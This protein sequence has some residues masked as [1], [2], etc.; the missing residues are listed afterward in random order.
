M[1]SIIKSHF[2]KG[3][4]GFLITGIF[5]IL[6]V[7]MMTIGLSI[8]FGM[9]KLYFNARN[10][11]N[12]ADC[13]ISVFE[14][15]GGETQKLLEDIL[16]KREDVESY[17]VRTIYYMEKRAVE[18]V[19]NR[20][21]IFNDKGQTSGFNSWVALNID[22]DSDK[23]KPHLRDTVEKDGYKFYITGNY[24][25]TMFCSIGDRVEFENGGNTYVGYVAGIY[26]DMA[27]IY[28]H[29]NIF[30]SGDLF[31]EIARISQTDDSVTEEYEINVRLDYVDEKK[32]E[33]AQY[34]VCEALT[35]ALGEYN[36]RNLMQDPTFSVVYCNDYMRETFKSGTKAF[37]LLLG[38]A[39]IAFSV[40]VAVIVAIV[41]AFLTRSNILDE[42]R[43]LGVWKA[44][45]YTTKQLRLSYL[46]IYGV[47]GLICLTIGAILGV[48][49]M[50]TFVGIITNMARLDL[51]KAIGT[52]I[53]GV[54]IAIVFIVAVLSAVVYLSTSKVKKITPLS[55]MRNNIQTHSFK[56]NKAPLNKSKISLDA[57]LGVKSVVGESRRS[58]MVVAIVLI[59][60]ILCSFVSVVYYN[61]K[62]DQTAIINMSGV[63]NADFYISFY[64]EDP[65]P[66]YDAIREMEG[67]EGEAYTTGIGTQ[68]NGEYRYGRLFSSFEHLRT[69]F[70]REGRYPKYPNEILIEEQYAKSKDIKIGDSIVISMDRDAKKSEK[71]CIIVGYFQ[72][73]FD[74]GAFIGFWNIMEELYTLDDFH[75][76]ADHLIYFEK[77]KAP[78][79]EQIDERLREVSGGE[80][81]KYNGFQTGRNVLENAVLN[82]VETAADAVM[83]VFFSITAIV[84]AL[85]LVMLVKLKL[86]RER[87]NYAVYKA[88]GYTTANIM[89]QIA[90]AMV[91]LGAIGSVI[92]TLFGALTTSPVLS[93]FGSFIGA[94]HFDFVIPWGY[95][96]AIAFAVPTLIYIVSMLCAIPVRRIHPASLL[97]ER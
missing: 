42:V 53:G 27:R 19:N 80:I 10:L 7:M 9:D 52:H 30:V 32:N 25:E 16:N 35:D 95:T 43:N 6:S 18:D 71:E 86:L 40:I 5:I 17:D 61:L 96:V 34:E 64:Y 66:Y 26:D 20:M 83:S 89:T 76:K 79:L 28:N 54:L 70:L 94:G 37:I 49:L 82:T 72:N 51:S 3:K 55:A 21:R 13:A 90:I 78:T 73:I 1:L 14:K 48:S 88:L 33:L 47:I 97:R 8:C 69:Q 44:L 93:L 57:H 77:G 92:G 45:G 4:T 29:V 85:L 68:I 60:S 62:V 56:R 67:F 74:N 50:P 15:S 11:S 38:T 81:V 65:S 2:H 36:I 41:T 23:F 87:R 58:V 63:E 91:I 84:I 59:M 75:N 31:D 39:M 46:A 24:A 12:S 22:D